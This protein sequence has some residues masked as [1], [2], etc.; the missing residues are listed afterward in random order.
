MLII[1]DGYTRECLAIEVSRHFNADVNLYRLTE[2][3]VSRC[4]DD[5]I[6]SDNGLEFTANAVP[7]PRDDSKRSTL[8]LAALR[9]TVTTRASMGRC[10]M[11]YSRGRYSTL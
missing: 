4:P 1:I 10:V 6:R 7:K 3:F 11:S 5:Y 2:P 8:N 9:R